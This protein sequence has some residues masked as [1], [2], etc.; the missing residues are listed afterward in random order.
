MHKNAEI[1]GRAASLA[2]SALG[3]G[4]AQSSAP[5]ECAG[6]HDRT[7]WLFLKRAALLNPAGA[8]SCEWKRGTR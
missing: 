3:H 5:V 2:V 1:V 8:Y 7:D 6:S 4:N